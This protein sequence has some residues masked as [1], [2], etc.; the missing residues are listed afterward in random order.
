MSIPIVVTGDDIAIAVT[1][2]RNGAVFAINPGATVKARLVDVDHENAY[3][4][5]VAQSSSAPGADWSVSL[6]SVQFAPADTTTITYQGLAKLEI[7]VDDA[8]KSTW[9]VP[10]VIRRGSIT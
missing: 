3:T 2:K 10:V 6:V 1:L 8:I 9:F 4:A 7:Q 5:E